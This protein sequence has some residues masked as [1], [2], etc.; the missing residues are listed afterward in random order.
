MLRRFGQDFVNGYVL[1]ENLRLYGGNRYANQPRWS[2]YFEI[3]A[4]GMVP[5]TGLVVGRFYDDVRAVISRQRL[6]TFEILLWSWTA[7]SVGFFTFSDFKLDHYIFP[8]VP[9]VCLIC[10]RAW[11]EARV[12]IRS[13][14]HAGVRLGMLLVG[15]LLV[16]VG[17]GCAYFV[18]ARLELPRSVMAVPIA[19]TVA[20]VMLIAIVRWREGIGAKPPEF[21]W[22]AIAALGVTYAGLIAVVM[23][24]LEG[25]KVIPEVAHWVAAQASHG[26]RVAT[27]RL[28]RWKPAFRFYLGRHVIFIDDP[29]EA[30]AL[31]RKPEPFYALMRRV[32]VDEFVAKGIP[33]VVAHEREGLWATSGRVLWRRRIPPEHFVVVTLNRTGR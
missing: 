8:A 27:F 6:D 11:A 21:P 28:N 3:L 33:L 31:F 4:V 19:I 14:R 23:P 7:A 18:I 15:P 32:H 12:D 22:I 5:W 29:Q 26:E 2:F 20:G 1:D 24:A 17:L 13:A 30:E 10:A 16:V 25:R 9:A